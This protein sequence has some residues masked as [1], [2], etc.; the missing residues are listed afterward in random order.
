M[1][2]A[3]AVFTGT[4]EES[5]TSRFFFRK[6]FF[7][8]DSECFKTY[9]KPKKLISKKFSPW[10]FFLGLNHFLTKMAKKWKFS[11]KISN[12][13]WNRFRMFQNVFSTEKVDFE[14]I[15]PVEFFPWTL[16]FFDKNSQ[17]V[18]IVEKI[19]IILNRYRMF[20]NV[21][22]NSIVFQV[23]GVFQYWRGS[24]SWKHSIPGKY[25]KNQI[26]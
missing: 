13:F 18:K 14:K 24:N 15:F 19:A 3:G 8:I 10:N 6:I 9:F 17:K 23:G 25:C 5:G 1:G 4:N 21:F 16:P 2:G 12:F 7:G 26:F 22:Y 11:K 20:Q